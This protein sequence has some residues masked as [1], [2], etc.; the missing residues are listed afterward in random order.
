[1]LCGDC[2]GGLADYVNDDV[3]LGEHDDVAAVRLDGGRPH[4]FRQ[5]TLEVRMHGVVILGYDE[6][7]RFRLPSVA[8][9]LLLLLE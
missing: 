1:M 8:I 9:D 2:D 3:G 5:K 6:P 4:A 7:A